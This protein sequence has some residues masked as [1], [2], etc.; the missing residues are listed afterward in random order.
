MRLILNLEY[1]RV[2]DPILRQQLKW[3]RNGAVLGI[4]PFTAFYVMP[5]MLGIPPTPYM[6]WAILFLPLIP[7]TWAYA[8][9]RYRLM[10]VDV[11]F[12]Q[13]YVYTLSTVAVL[14]V[15]YL[16]FCHDRQGGRPE[17]RAQS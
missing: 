12:Q 17:P 9:V 3:L 8:I 10:D 14:G 7:M 2:E 6:N 4:V 1:R 16:L 13:G 5:F 11:I 15:F